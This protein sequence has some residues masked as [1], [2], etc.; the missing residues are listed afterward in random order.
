VT[1]VNTFAWGSDRYASARPLYP[2]ALFD[3]IAANCRNHDA[4]W[5]CATGNGQA[6]IELARIFGRVEATDISDAQ[7]A[8][9]FAA[10]NIRYSAQPAERTSF[11]GF[12]FD[13]IA[14]A[15]ALHWFDFDLFWPEVRRVARP[16]ALFC[17]WG[18]AWFRGA[19]PVER[20]LFDPVLR[21]VEPHWAPHNR[22]LWDGYALEDVRW[23]FELLSV[24][25]L[26]I[27]VDWS[28]DQ[29]IAYVCT[30]SAFK[31]AAAAG[32]DAQLEHVVAEARLRLRAET[33]YALWVPLTIR[34][35]YVD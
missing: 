23:P 19:E 24:P 11:P 31:R 3:W 33:R 7:V 28:V 30:W 15:Q 32:V 13:L 6:A 34:A 22:I 29:I 8:K 4:A 12:S 2:A 26:R 35:G 14:V 20:D 27:T 10:P 1:P 9:G 21:L 25:E 16:G 17:A 5:D 18:Y